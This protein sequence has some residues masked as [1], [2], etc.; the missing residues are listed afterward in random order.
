MHL[1][2]CLR[3]DQPPS[4]EGQGGGVDGCKEKSGLR[5]LGL[6]LGRF[7][8]AVCDAGKHADS[9]AHG[10]RNVNARAAFSYDHVL[11]SKRLHGHAVT[12]FPV[13]TCLRW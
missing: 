12:G 13:P 3:Y 1:R 11:Y 2:S 7:I 4:G 10:G 9:Q 5:M 6:S 8:V